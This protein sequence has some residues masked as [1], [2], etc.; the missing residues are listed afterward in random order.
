MNSVSLHFLDA[1][2]A[3]REIELIERHPEV[4]QLE[5]LLVRSEALSLLFG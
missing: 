2:L 3:R 4:G 5:R 1:D